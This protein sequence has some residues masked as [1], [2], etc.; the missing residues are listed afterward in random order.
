MSGVAPPVG[1]HSTVGRF[2]LKIVRHIVM[3]REVR[4]TNYETSMGG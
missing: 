2:P 4:L 3:R 1:F